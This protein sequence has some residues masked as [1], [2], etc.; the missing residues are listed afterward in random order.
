VLKYKFMRISLFD[1]FI[2][3]QNRKTV[4]SLQK[5]YARKSSSGN[6][7]EMSDEAISK[8]PLYPCM[9]SNERFSLSL[10]VLLCYGKKIP[11]V[12]QN[13]S[14]SSDSSTVKDLNLSYVKRITY[15]TLKAIVDF[16]TL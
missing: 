9:V 8:R 15:Y 11:P 4:H 5:F 3:L 14:T 1:Y 16:S 2:V 10:N 7:R 13:W 6:R 12:Y